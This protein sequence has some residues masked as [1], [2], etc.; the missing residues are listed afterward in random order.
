[1]SCNHPLS[2]T[3]K[4]HSCI[5][6]TNGALQTDT[7]PV[8]GW[9]QVKADSGPA[10]DPRKKNVQ[11]TSVTSL[12]NNDVLN[13]TSIVCAVICSYHFLQHYWLKCTAVDRPAASIEFKKGV[14]R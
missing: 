1:M 13:Y 2:S 7:F 4:R 5:K 8:R 10:C 14:D 12:F 11:Y 6:L 9:H 3:G